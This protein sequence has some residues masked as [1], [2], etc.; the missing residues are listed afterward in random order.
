MSKLR[1]KTKM[2]KGDPSATLGKCSSGVRDVAMA[3]PGPALVTSTGSITAPARPEGRRPRS[4][5]HLHS[6]ASH[7][8]S[9]SRQ[10]H[11]HTQTHAR[12]SVPN[13][14]NTSH[15]WA[16]CAQ[17]AKGSQF[18]QLHF[19]QSF[20][21]WLFCFLLSASNTL[22]F[23]WV[24]LNLVKSKQWKR[25]E[26]QQVWTELINETLSEQYRVPRI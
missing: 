26:N 18:L 13:C 19:S 3:C 14:I 5:A 10:A 9:A 17:P 25:P 12:P 11:S 7:L 20:I 24:P 22:F 16:S 2:K 4:L 6:T 8:P 1:R 21:D 23:Y 15:S